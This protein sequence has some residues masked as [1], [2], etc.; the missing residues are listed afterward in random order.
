MGHKVNP[1]IFR[2]GI[3]K[4]WNSKWFSDTNYISHL[5]QDITIRKYVET[6][7][8]EA[9][10]DRVVIDRDV[11]KI[12][13]SIYSARPGMIIGKGGAGIEDMK[14]YIR[15][16]ILKTKKIKVEINIKE[17]NKPNLSARII[18]QNIAIDLEKRMPYRRVMK[19]YIDQVIKA[20][21]QGVKIVCGGRLGGV[22]IARSESLSEG[23]IPLHTIRA[24]IDYSRLTAS[25]TYGVIGVKVWIY[26]GEYF[27]KK[28]ELAE[29][30]KKITAASK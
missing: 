15:E 29:Y 18:A 4:T 26:K 3:S 24:D 28:K 9:S 22:E 17:V 6:K 2:I 13:I 16:K 27:E 30:E 21:G 25:T 12:D 7:L 19:K 11:E 14:K 20:G 1:K 8:K 23:K 5:K 10:L